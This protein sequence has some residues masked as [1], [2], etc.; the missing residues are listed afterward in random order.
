[1][2][3]Q[4]HES[5]AEHSQ[6]SLAQAVLDRIEKEA[7]V[8]S[9]RWQ[10]AVVQYGVWVLWAISVIIGALSIAVILFAAAHARF[11]IFETTHESIWAF[12]LQVLP[13]IWIVL[14]A[15]MA[16]WAYYNLRHTRHGYRYPFW[17]I[18]LS[19][20]FFSILGGL[21]LHGFEVGMLIDLSLGNDFAAYPSVAHIEERMWDQ[22]NQGLL[23][24][25]I[26]VPMHPT[27]TIHFVDDHGAQWIV[28]TDEL[29]NVDRVLLLSGDRVRLLGTTTDPVSH[30][31]YV[32]GVFPWEFNHAFSTRDLR[33][34]RQTFVSRVKQY[35]QTV[36]NTQ[37]DNQPTMRTAATAPTPHICGQL[38]V[39]QRAQF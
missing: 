24:G 19:S 18:L 15:G 32:C 31:F 21:V 3:T 38:N 7:V 16:V 27:T 34:D 20:L 5:A 22:P 37:A 33:R 4:T 17:Q 25:Q 30:V 23:I 35:V 10:F 28:R 11:A 39:V 6:S 26:I 29:P 12:Y 13:Y 1:M 36:A 8:P 9:P 14:F 2:N